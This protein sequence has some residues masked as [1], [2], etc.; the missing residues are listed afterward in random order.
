MALQNVENIKKIVSF[1]ESAGATHAGAIG[2]AANMYAESRCDPMCVEALL[3]KRYKEEGFLKWDYGLYDENTYKQY[4]SYFDSGAISEAE[5]LSPRQYTGVKHQYGA[6]ICQWTTK[7]R[8]EKWLSLAKDDAKPLY[9]LDLQLNLLY[10]ELK[11]TY[12]DVWNVVHYGINIDVT[13]N[14]VLRHFEQPANAGTLLKSRIAY[15]EQIK[16]ML[17]GEGSDTVSITIGSA[18]IDENG[19]AHG[20]KAGDQTGREVS[21]QSYYLHGKGW[22]A[23]RF[24]N[25]EFA[26][27]CAYAMRAACAN[28]NWGYDQYQRL[29]G[30]QKV[31]AYGYDPAKLNSPAETD[32]SN[33]V[34]VCFIYAC[35]VDPGDFDTSGEASSLLST[36]LVEEVSFDKATG[37]GLCE[38]DILA[39]RTKGH[40]VIVTGGAERS[41]SNSSNTS[42]NSPQKVTGGKYMFTL[43]IIK[44]GSKG[45]AVLLF[46]EIFISRNL[47][48][49]WKQKDIDL[50]GVCG[51]D[52]V[53]AIKW[54]QKQRGL[55]ADGECGPNTWKDLL[56][57]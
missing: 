57:L 29:S 34:R 22:R 36:G 51:P 14:Y 23:F 38:G 30:M 48:R 42:G 7:G 49:N 28:N 41:S 32:C 47:K 52:T 20:G 39:T 27:R 19:H 35:G 1:L 25:P 37:T 5:F 44:Q 40:T 6:G 21:E 31:K 3:I 12:T 2:M 15:A 8:K 4:W 55:T 33:L 46:Q 56:A 11:E 16:E 13:T 50:D 9:D 10:L 17:D 26:K 18:R 54:Y 53:A 45:A 24:K 43:P